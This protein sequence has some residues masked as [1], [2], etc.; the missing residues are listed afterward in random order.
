MHNGK[1]DWSCEN[2]SGDVIEN[3]LGHFE[4]THPLFAS[5]NLAKFC[6]RF[7]ECLVF[8]ILQIMTTNVIPQLANDIGSRHRLVPNNFSQL[9]IR[10]HWF[11]ERATRLSFA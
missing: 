6:I 9:W 1:T 7:D 3:E 5:K 8:R 10:L 11:H 4:H 2:T